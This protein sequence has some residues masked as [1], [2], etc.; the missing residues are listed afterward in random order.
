[1]STSETLPTILIVED[2]EVLGEVLARVLTGHD[3]VALHVRTAGEALELVQK[4]CPR[5][6]L[7]D[8]GL[9]DGTGLKLTESLKAIRARLPVIVLST[10]RLEKS[11]LPG[12]GERLVTKSI[13]L[14]ELR[15][16]IDAALLESPATD[17]ETTSSGH[18]DASRSTASRRPSMSH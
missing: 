16:T 9:R 18:D 5:L 8:A 12:R 2:D 7:V 4:G 3:R 10:H 11:D 14:P 17:L 6:V 1:M 15:R 13:D